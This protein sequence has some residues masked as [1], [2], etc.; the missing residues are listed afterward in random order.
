MGVTVLR[1][2]AVTP[3]SR[4]APEPS[5]KGWRYLGFSSDGEQVW[6]RYFPPNGKH[7]AFLVLVRFNPRTGSR[8]R[9]YQSLAHGDM[10]K[11]P[12]AIRKNVQEFVDRLPHATMRS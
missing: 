8:R 9:T 6:E 5:D 10:P 11:V 7:E 4:G 12:S 3:A 1:D 2:L